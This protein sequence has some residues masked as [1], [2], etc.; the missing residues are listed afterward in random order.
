MA[1]DKTTKGYTK[2]LK[3][4]EEDKEKKQPDVFNKTKDEDLRQSLENRIE[5]IKNSVENGKDTFG[6]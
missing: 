5:K 6:V 2:N 3:Q 4:S 1:T